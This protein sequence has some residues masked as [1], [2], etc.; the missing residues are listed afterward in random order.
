MWESKAPPRE[1]VRRWHARAACKRRAQPSART[2]DSLS[3][4]PRCLDGGD[5]DLRLWLHVR[6]FLVLDL[7]REITQLK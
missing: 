7:T 3:A 1:G 6:V 5:V 4:P 2:K